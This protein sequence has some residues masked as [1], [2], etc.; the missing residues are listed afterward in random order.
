[1]S[2][3]APLPFVS[4]NNY[5]ADATALFSR[6]SS[7]PNGA[8]KTVI[9]DTIIA[10]KAAG[11]WAKLDVLYMFAAHDSQAALL[12][13]KSGNFDG[14]ANNSPTFTTDRGFTGNGSSAYINSNFNPTTASSPSFV[15]TSA[16]LSIWSRTS[17][18]GPNAYGEVGYSSSGNSELGSRTNSG[19]VR[20]YVNGSGSIAINSDGSGFHN[21]SLRTSS[22]YGI[23]R[24]TT[25]L[26]SGSAS[27]LAPVNEKI[28]FLGSGGNRTNKQLA[29]GSIGGGLTSTQQTDFYN[30]L[31]TYMTAVGA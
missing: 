26:S 28:Y 4:S 13:W 8:R 16:H 2:L 29:M 24:N 20:G 19:Y 1:M 18:L 11:V 10:L 31:Q 6:M 12:N 17:G 9:S 23:V 30:A 22:T 21:I 25:T 7:Q 3:F 14:T 5:D 15:Q 27:P